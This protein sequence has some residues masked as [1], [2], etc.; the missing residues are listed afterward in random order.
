[1]IPDG[2]NL[3]I[4]KINHKLMLIRGPETHT[5]LYLKARQA[6]HVPDDVIT[7]WEEVRFPYNDLAAIISDSFH[8]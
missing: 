4:I 2:W 5:E 1:M 8:S 6:F 7:Q 3:I